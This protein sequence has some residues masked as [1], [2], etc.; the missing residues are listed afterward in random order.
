MISFFPQNSKDHLKDYYFGT[1]DNIKKV[2][3]K[4][5]IDQELP[6]NEFQLLPGV[7]TTPSAMCS[8]SRK[9]LSRR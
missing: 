2:N 6:V 4:K 3:F 9:L 5:S 8:F 7:R 1:V